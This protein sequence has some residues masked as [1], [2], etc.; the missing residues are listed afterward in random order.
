MVELVTPW[1]FGLWGDCT[2]CTGPPL[3]PVNR[4]P[5]ELLSCQVNVPSVSYST[6]R[7]SWWM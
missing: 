1:A 5:G 4:V 2:Q 7:S 3:L 6:S